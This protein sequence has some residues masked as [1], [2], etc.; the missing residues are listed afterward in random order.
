[1]SKLIYRYGAMNSGKSIDVLKVA[2]NYEERN[3]KVLLFKP[4]KD[5]KAGDKVS[6]RIGIERKVDHI[7][8]DTDSILKMVK[9]GIINLDKISCIITDECQFFTPS[10]I[11]E[12]LYISKAIDI[13]VICYGLRTDFKTNGF[14][15]AIRLME[16]ADI[17]EE[18]PTICECGKKAKFNARIVNGKYTLEGNQVAIDGV[19]KITYMSLCPECYLKKVLKI[20]L[21][22]KVIYDDTIKKVTKLGEKA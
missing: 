21:S 4:G 1:M 3:N 11:D 10:Q 12:L 18:I 20:K 15:G 17:I 22:K 6:S 13:P 7:I 9:E 14:P 16:L 5:T 8:K 2:H 19:N